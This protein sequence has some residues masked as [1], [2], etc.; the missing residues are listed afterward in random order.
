MKINYALFAL[1]CGITWLLLTAFNQNGCKSKAAADGPPRPATETRSVEFLQKKLLNRQNETKNI[2]S[3]TARAKV[4]SE[5]DGMSISVNAN[6]IWIRDSIIWMNAKKFGLEAM[7]ILVTRDSVIVL[8]RLEKTATSDGLETLRRRYSL[9]E[10]DVFQLLQN[11][12]LGLP[13]IPF[14]PTDT[15]SDIQNGLHRLLYDMGQYSGEYFVEEGS[16]LL[17]GERFVKKLDNTTIR[18]DFEGHQKIPQMDGLFSLQRKIDA[19]SPQQGRQGA[20]IELEDVQAN[21]N[22]SYK[23]EIPDHYTRN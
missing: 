21:T 19:Y 1:Y 6:I 16:F 14:K 7:R 20:T 3:I 12:L 9:P 10:G 8:N 23:F 17:K 11:T 13:A 15:K 2:R 5:G 22:P 4:F 18:L